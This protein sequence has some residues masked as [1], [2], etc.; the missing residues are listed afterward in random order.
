[1]EDALIPSFQQISSYQLQHLF[2]WEWDLKFYDS[3]LGIAV[4]SG[5]FPRYWVVG[6]P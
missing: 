5:N 1:M 6:T 3:T 2:V 4:I